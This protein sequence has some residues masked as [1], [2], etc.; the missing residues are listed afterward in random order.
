MQNIASRISNRSYSF[1]WNDPMHLTEV[2]ICLPDL[3]LCDQN[4]GG[5]W[6][7]IFEFKLQSHEP[8]LIWYNGGGTKSSQ[9]SLL[10]ES[11]MAARERE[12][13][14]FFI[15]VQDKKK[16]LLF[17]LFINREFELDTVDVYRLHDKVKLYHTGTAKL[18]RITR[19]KPFLRLVGIEEHLS[20]AE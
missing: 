2:K 5:D 19:R 14:P 16:D 11:P 8:V 13:T 6:G 3:K 1:V 7:P 10:I 12:K 9:T 17:H 4:V 20:F 18:E 15:V